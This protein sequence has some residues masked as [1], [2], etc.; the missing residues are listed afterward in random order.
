MAV[1][2]VLEKPMVTSA[3]VTG[4]AAAGEASEKLTSAVVISRNL[5][6]VPPLSG[7]PHN[8]VAGLCFA[9]PLT[10]LDADEQGLG[11]V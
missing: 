5:R 3:V 10:R 11:V 1:A 7:L 4:S 2:M 6:K 8:G 9:R